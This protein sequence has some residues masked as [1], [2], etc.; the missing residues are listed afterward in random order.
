MVVVKIE[1]WPLGNEKHKRE[2]GRAKIWNDGTG[3]RNT[4]NYE[5]ELSHSGLFY[6]KDKT[7]KKS[8]VKNH[9]RMHSPYSLVYHAFKNALSLKET[10]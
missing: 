3:D 6:N 10:K 2:I 9:P 7:W 4:G 5:A 8:K 1:L